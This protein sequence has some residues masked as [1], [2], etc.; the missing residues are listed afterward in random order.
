M[1]FSQKTMKIVCALALAGCM[2][3]LGC[4]KKPDAARLPLDGFR[5]DGMPIV[6]RSVELTVLT[7]RWGDMGDS[8][9]KNQWLIDLEK[10]TNVKI[11]WQVVSSSDWNE[12]KSILLAGGKLPDI[13]MGN[14]TFNDSDIINNMEFFLPLD[15]LIDQYMPNY[16]RAMEQVPALRN[17]STFPDGKIYSLSKNLP[18]RPKSRNQPIINKKW[19][20]NAGLPVPGT[21]AELTEALRAF[22]T[23][24]VNGN[25][26]P[27]DEYPISFVGNV[28]VDMLNPFGITDTNASY[29]TVKDGKPFF[30][31][32]SP[33][34]RDAIRWVRGLWVEGLIDP[35]SFTQDYNMLM[36]KQQ[37][38]AAPL[39][40]MA[41]EWTHDAVFG[42]WSDQ[43]I[44][45]PPIAGPGGARYAGG[46]PDG[47]F[48]IMR[49]EALIT[50]FCK[51]PE[52]AARWLDE[53]YTSEASI[54]NFWGAIGTVITKNADGTYE[55][56]NPPGGTSADA[57]YWDQSLRDFGPKFVEPGFDERILL[58]KT[59]GDGLKMETSRIA[60]AYV[61]YPYPDVIYTTQENDELSTLTT[62]IINYVLQS[63]AKWV[64]QGNIDADWPAYV[65]QL[66]L[67]GLNRFIEIRVD[68]YNRFKGRQ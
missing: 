35:E 42:K 5:V 2:L 58:S 40:G 29:M 53:F 51:Y 18:A 47:V 49:N 13:I 37:N 10:R 24:D 52:V 50:S 14:Q 39:V 33:E 61:M 26:D 59:S 45:I 16:K 64:T 65:R 6:R 19:L 43:Y 46:N 7:M 34:Y 48:S 9:T 57:W 30:Y 22:K 60:D 38:A 3:A 63:Q 28:H 66:E 8:F 36:G 23:K 32:T 27:N 67:M 1:F 41:F 25:G 31:P 56:N 62:D 20:D 17:I 21:I 54:Q 15:D 11:K 12:Q 68:A 4:T 44:A 55:L